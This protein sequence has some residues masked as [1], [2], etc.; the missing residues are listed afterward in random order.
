MKKEVPK[1]TDGE[2]RVLE[3]LWERG[4]ASASELVADLKE[5]AQWNRNTTYTFINRLV[6]KGIIK[7]E[8]PGF[9]CTP[10]YSREE[11]RVAEAKTFLNRLYEG[12]LKVLV[13]SFINNDELSKEEIK[14]LKRL[15]NKGE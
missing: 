6:D 2:L 15:I 8:E 11:I 7:R 5:G 9:I 12:S 1:I 10:L 3:A 13:T 14:E 4:K